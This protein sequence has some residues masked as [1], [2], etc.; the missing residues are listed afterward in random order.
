MS[1]VIDESGAVI[2]L[3]DDYFKAMLDADEAALRRIFDPRASVIGHEDGKFDFASL[4]AFIASTSDAKTGDKPFDCRVEGLTTVG[5]I[6]V[7]TVGNYCYGTWFTD[8]LSMLKVDG[9]WRIVAKTYYAHP[10]D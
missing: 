9:S 7:V 4:D 2:A 3:A 1:D 6:A 5:D 10:E 8:H